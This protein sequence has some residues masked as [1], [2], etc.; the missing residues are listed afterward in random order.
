MPETK[1]VL[2]IQGMTCDGCSQSIEHSLKRQRGVRGVKVNWR[3]GV[4]EVLFDPEETEV[5]EIL[6]NRIFQ[7]H[8]KAQVS[9][10]DA[11]GRA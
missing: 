11:A 8:Y 7:R 9:P 5:E 3:T 2:N 4:G 10:A 6:E 1:A